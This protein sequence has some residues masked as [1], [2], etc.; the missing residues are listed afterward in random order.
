MADDRAEPRNNSR[1]NSVAG[2]TERAT[3]CATAAQQPSLKALAQQA[4]ARN[5]ARNSRATDLLR[6]ARPRECNN[7]TTAESEPAQ[8]VTCGDLLRVARPRECNNATTAE[9]P[10]SST[11]DRLRRIAA[12]HGLDWCEIQ[13]W[14]RPEDIEASGA[15]LDSEDERDRLGVV[16][17]L[18]ILADKSIPKMP[19]SWVD[20]LDR[21]RRPN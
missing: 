13:R 10:P 14:L 16:F 19:P 6:V 21:Q 8:P 7:A 15:Y 4:L 12:E 3:A 5:S 2:A 18:K 9:P 1:N 11:E 20:E 17:W